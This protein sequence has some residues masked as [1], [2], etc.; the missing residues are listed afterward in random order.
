[1]FDDLKNFSKDKAGLDNVPQPE[2]QSNPIKPIPPV[3]NPARVE[4]IFSETDQDGPVPGKKDSQSA[5][6]SGLPPKAKVG[7]KIFVIAGAI[8][9]GLV[10]IGAVGWYYYSSY[11]A[12]NAI[13]EKGDNVNQNNANQD[14]GFLNGQEDKNNE[15]K[16]EDGAAVVEENNS[17]NNVQPEPASVQPQAL[18]SDYDGVSDEEEIKLG[19]NINSVDSDND[20]LFDREEIKVYKTDPLNPDTDGDSFLDGDEVMKGYDPNG[21]GK[22]LKLPQ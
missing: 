17:G 7:G 3:S 6:L 22:L 2:F 9:A 11:S 15:A 10:V 19:A 16:K 1:M 20:K 21:P 18:D 14:N 4:D 12:K 8:L 13:L 5:P